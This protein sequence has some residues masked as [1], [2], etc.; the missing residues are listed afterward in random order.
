MKVREQGNSLVVTVPKKFGIK[1][2]TEVIAV[3]GRDGSFSYIPKTNNPFK[4]PNVDFEHDHEEFDDTT[5]GR[6]EI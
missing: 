6:E 4:D 2:G 1:S 5:T 3:K